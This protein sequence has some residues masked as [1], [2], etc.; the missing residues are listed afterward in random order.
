MASGRDIAAFVSKHTG[1]NFVGLYDAAEERDNQMEMEAK[2]SF[3][4]LIERIEK[5]QR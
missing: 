2:K 5:L 4:N 1:K 3:N